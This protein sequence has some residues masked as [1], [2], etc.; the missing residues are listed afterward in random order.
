MYVVAGT[1]QAC[2]D[3]PYAK[4]PLELEQ[5]ISF[6]DWCSIIVRLTFQ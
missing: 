6:L 5:S 1:L 2:N 4:E 3:D